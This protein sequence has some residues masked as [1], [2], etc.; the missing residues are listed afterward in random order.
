MQQCRQYR[1]FD[2]RI[3]RDRASTMNMQFL[4]NTL[5]FRS[6]SEA[7]IVC[8]SIGFDTLDSFGIRRCHRRYVRFVASIDASKNNGHKTTH[9]IRF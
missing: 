9:N 8:P 3:N 2:Q 4:C 1:L 5:G 6:D 7:F